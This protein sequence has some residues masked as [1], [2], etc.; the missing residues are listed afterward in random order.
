MI[1]YWRPRPVRNRNKRAIIRD[2][3]KRLTSSKNVFPYPF[4]FTYPLK[5]LTNVATSK[6]QNAI[7][8]N[9]HNDAKRNISIFF[10]SLDFS[11]FVDK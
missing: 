1:V 7:A 10:Y 8:G 6:T 3:T 2:L 11:R 9:R 5:G 4:K